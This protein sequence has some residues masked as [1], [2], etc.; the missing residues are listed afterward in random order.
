[1]QAAGAGGGP[2]FHLRSFIPRSQ[3]LSPAVEINSSFQGAASGR[4][5]EER[6][7][8]DRRP[9]LSRGGPLA[10]PHPRPR[11]LARN[12]SW[13]EDSGLRDTHAFRNALIPGLTRGREGQMPVCGAGGGA[14]GGR[15]VT[16]AEF[17]V[18]RLGTRHVFLA[19]GQR[20][21]VVG[22]RGP[23]PLLRQVGHPPPHA[24]RPHFPESPKCRGP[25]CCARRA[26]R[27][28]C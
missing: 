20:R 25:G 16:C 13:E 12:S 10:P 9:P 14:R 8:E 11:C 27:S 5:T 15:T 17:C 23:V 21:S 3:H 18:L 2:C 28:S 24:R 7:P 1:M 26:L 19:W 4:A 6:G 22:L